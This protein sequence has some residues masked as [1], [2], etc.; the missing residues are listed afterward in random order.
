MMAPPLKMPAKPDG[1][2]GCQFAGF[3]KVAPTARKIT[4]A[5]SFTATM[6][7]FACADSRIPRTSNT[8]STKTMRK[9]GTVEERASPVSAAPDRR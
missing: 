6:M 9:A 1:A 3:T 7:L 2:N 4:M 5:P 8:V